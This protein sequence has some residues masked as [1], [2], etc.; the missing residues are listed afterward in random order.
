MGAERDEARYVNQPHSP[1][2]WTLAS[3]PASLTPAQTP[4][5][6]PG[7]SYLP[8]LLWGPLLGVLTVACW[9]RRRVHG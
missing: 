8:L 3:T 2:T 5:A 6:L 4:D 1:R 7:L 9:R